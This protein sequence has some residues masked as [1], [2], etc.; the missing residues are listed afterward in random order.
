[1]SIEFDPAKRCVVVAVFY[2]LPGNTEAVK[3]ILTSIIPEVH[4]EPGCDFYALHELPDGRLCFVEA[5]ETREHWVQHGEESTVERINSL[6]KD[7]LS[8]DVD[9]MEM[10]AVQ[11]GDSMGLIPLHP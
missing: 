10:Y 11:A 2:P 3:S 4:K 1:M 6:T 8:R 5:W 7:L 9:V